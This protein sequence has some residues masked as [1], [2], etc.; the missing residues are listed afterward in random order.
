MHNLLV[1]VIKV[2]HFLHLTS[3]GGSIN[4]QMLPLMI[5]ALRRGPVTGFVCGG[6]IYGLFSILADGY[7]FATY[8]FDYVIG[9]GSV[10]IM[11][12]FNSLIFPKEE[13]PLWQREI[14]SLYYIGII[15]YTC[16]IC[17]VKYKKY[18]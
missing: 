6:I 3:L 13:K 15:T 18:Y 11:G 12:L 14:S 4:L 2:L 5:I 8:P 1:F 10:G 17:Q 7:P 16:I 9:F